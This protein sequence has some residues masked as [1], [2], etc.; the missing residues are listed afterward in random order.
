MSSVKARW[1]LGE[2]NFDR[3]EKKNKLKEK[4]QSRQQ[5][6]NGTEDG[7]ISPDLRVQLAGPI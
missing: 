3:G 1:T 6:K 2:R 4:R 5:S 7:S